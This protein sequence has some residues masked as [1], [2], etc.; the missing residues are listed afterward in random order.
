[1]AGRLIL[2]KRAMWLTQISSPG[3]N[4]SRICWRVVSPSAEKKRENRSQLSGRLSANSGFMQCG[5]RAF[6]N[7]TVNQTKISIAQL[8]NMS[9]YSNAMNY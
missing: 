4:T 2:N 9:I 7:Q 5:T 6:R 8:E 3:S 1:M